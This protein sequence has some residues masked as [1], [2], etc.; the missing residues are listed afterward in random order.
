MSKP[1]KMKGSPMQRNFGISP[2]KDNPYAA[3][4]GGTETDTELEILYDQHAK[5]EHP[6]SPVKHGDG[7]GEAPLTDVQQK[8]SDIKSAYIKK[9]GGSTGGSDAEWNAYQA[10]LKSL[11]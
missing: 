2:M 3:Q 9:H 11:D 7:S 4:K 5:T 6:H 1:F 8:R 10:L